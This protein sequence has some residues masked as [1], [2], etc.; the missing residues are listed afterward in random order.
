M[1]RPPDARRVTGAQDSVC[2]S[3]AQGE[4]QWLT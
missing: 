3:D 2:K 1:G 4:E